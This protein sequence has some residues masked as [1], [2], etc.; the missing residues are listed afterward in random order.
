MQRQCNWE[1]VAEGFVDDDSCNWKQIIRAH[2]TSNGSLFNSPATTAAAVIHCR[3][4]KCFHYLISI[5]KNSNGWG[6]KTYYYLLEI[7]YPTFWCCTR[8]VVNV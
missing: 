3:D 8:N 1:C 6:T 7:F 2:Q 5:L 4:D